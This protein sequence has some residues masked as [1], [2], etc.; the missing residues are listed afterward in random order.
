LLH[1]PVSFDLTLTTLLLP[2]TVGGRVCVADLDDAAPPREEIT[3]CKITPSH[4]P[5]LAALPDAF[6]PTEDLVIGGEQLLG[7]ELREWRRR[8]PGV[9]VVNEYGPTE[10]TVGTVAYRITPGE[11][12]GGG[13]VP[14]GRPIRNTGVYLLDEFLRPVPPG[15]VGEVYLA[16]AALARGYLG[17][18]GMTAER[19]VADPYASSAGQA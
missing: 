17:K 3:F 7:E 16:G 9:T 15:V 11:T 8:H 5:L 6:A 4:L 1:S 18:P 19:F 12:L 14:V 13:A 2:L 10:A